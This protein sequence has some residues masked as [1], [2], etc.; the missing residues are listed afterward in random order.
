MAR[1]WLGKTQN[2]Q[3]L[4][5]FL[6]GAIAL[7]VGLLALVEPD[8]LVAPF[9]RIEEATIDFRFRVFRGPRPATPDIIIVMVDEKS[10]KEIG[11]WPWSRATQ[12]LLV[13]GIANG[14]ARVIGLDVMY[15]EPEVTDLKRGLQEVRASAQATGAPKAV[16]GLLDLK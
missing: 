1:V 5:F 10:I 9:R 14:G 12:A 3:Q 6:A 16:Q 4:G 13:E 11:R 2:I 8:L 7:T 15:P